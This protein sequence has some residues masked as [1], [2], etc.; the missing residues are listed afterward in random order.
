MTDQTGG[1]RRLLVIGAG[2]HAG[3]VIDVARSAGF[4]PVAALDA[5]AL[6]ATCNG[7]EVVGDDSQA[8]AYLDSGVREAVVALGDNKLR[9]TIGARLRDVGFAFPTLVHASAII[10]P[11]AQIG[12]GT[13]VM[14]AAVI[15]AGARIGEFAIINTAAVIE[16]DCIIGDGAHIAPRTVLGGCVSVGE[17][18][19]VGI[20]S[21][22][23]PRSTIGG[24]TIVGAGSTVIGTIEADTVVMGCPAKERSAR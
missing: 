20:G 14:P 5:G 10:S 7:V 17:L 4:R 1:E 19:F 18:A 13:V 24:R 16:H 8:Q 22:A 15:N 9:S 3:V 6:G 11:S 23:R 2:G 12:A 21:A